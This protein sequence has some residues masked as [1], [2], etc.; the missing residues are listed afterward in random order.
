MAAFGHSERPAIA[1]D[2]IAG[3]DNL[4]AIHIVSHGGPGFLRLGSGV[5]TL[6]SLETSAATLSAW[7]NALN[8]DGDLLLWGCDVAADPSG[9]AFVERL[10]AVTGADVGASL[11]ITGRGGDWDLEYRSGP[12]ETASLDSDSWISADFAESWQGRLESFNQIENVVLDKQ[13]PNGSLQ[14]QVITGYNL[15]VN[16]NVET[17]ATKGPEAAHLGV[18]VTNTS[19]TTTLENV[20]I[21]IGDLL[22]LAAVTGTPGVY[23]TPV[24]RR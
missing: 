10:A 13:R 19:K 16:S 3:Y 17:L 20:T 4:D 7:G 12:I 18:I 2:R 9:A 23:P 5:Q 6:S 1:N 24:R 22:D 11:D 14:L 8:Q 15:V 21:N